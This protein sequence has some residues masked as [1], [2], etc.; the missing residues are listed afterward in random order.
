MILAHAANPDGSN[1]R[2]GQCPTVR[3]TP[4]N[5]HWRAIDLQA[6]VLMFWVAQEKQRLRNKTFGNKP[7]PLDVI[8]G[9]CRSGTQLRSWYDLLSVRPSE[10]ILNGSN[11]LVRRARTR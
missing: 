6:A 7:L 4:E 2:K 1:F 11:G 10:E 3:F 8:R 9:C 5:G